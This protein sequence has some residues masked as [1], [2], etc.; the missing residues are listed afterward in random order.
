VPGAVLAPAASDSV[1]L[2]PAVTL[3][4]LKLAVA[5]AG[6]P[7]ADSATL[8]A[9]PEVTAVA[10]VEV[11]A[12][13]PAVEATLDGLAPIEKS[14]TAVPVIVQLTLVEC[15]ADGEVPVTVTVTVPVGVAAPAVKLRVELP[16]A[17]TLGEDK[18]ADAPAGSPLTD[19]VTVSA[20]PLVTAVAIV[21]DAAAPPCTDETL[22]GLALI[23]KSFAVAPQPGSRNEPTWV[24]Q[25]K[26]PFAG[27]NSV[28]K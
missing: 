26:E 15:V 25:L 7:L 10:I 3:V 13:P 1:A 28:V 22:A 19:R 18:L 2:A 6:T 9:L 14:L 8:C 23:E 27:M 4:G 20:A 16:P 17:V 12:A 24:R 5:P 21:V 11:A